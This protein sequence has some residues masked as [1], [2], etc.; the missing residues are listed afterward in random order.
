M[1]LSVII[2]FYISISVLIIS[3]SYSWALMGPPSGEG[4]VLFSADSG[5]HSI[6]DLNN[7]KICGSHNSFEAFRSHT[8]VNSAKHANVPFSEGVPA[9]KMGI[10]DAVVAYSTDRNKIHEIGERMQNN[11]AFKVLY[12]P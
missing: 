6:E 11:I 7:R 3:N 5:I 2:L 12:F 8:G 1:S 10:C 4:F 9:I